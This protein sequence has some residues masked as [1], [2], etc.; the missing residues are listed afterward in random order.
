[1]DYFARQKELDAEL[2]VWKELLTLGQHFQLPQAL[3]FI[4]GMISAG[5][6]SDAQRLWRQALEVSR[7]PREAQDES[8]LVFNRGFEHDFANGGFDW[9]EQQSADDSIV[10]D[11]EVTRFGARSLRVSFNGKSNLDFHNVFQYVPVE[12]RRRYR[13]EAYLKSSALSTDSG[14][15]F[16][17]S[18]PLHPAMTQTFTESVTGTQPWT[19]IDTEFV[20]GP[21][22]RLVSIVL[23]RTP[24]LK[25]DNK[26]GGT[27]WVDDVSIVA[28]AGDDIN[29][30]RQR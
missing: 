6:V 30:G 14:M 11:P 18:D 28:L 13:F 12:P 26:L 9:R 3:P 5:R 19:H 21:T 20:T 29:K 8:S 24:S 22:T 25:F 27:V 1:M 10:F 4:D 16:L 23:R 15:R 7:W 17:I 2:S